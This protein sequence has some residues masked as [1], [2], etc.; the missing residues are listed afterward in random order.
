M[1]AQALRRVIGGYVTGFG[2]GD[3]GGI[4]CV[5]WSIWNRRRGESAGTCAKPVSELLA[6]VAAPSQLRLF[7][8]ARPA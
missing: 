7:I 3:R 5:F 4:A 8:E 6:T 2:R 1:M